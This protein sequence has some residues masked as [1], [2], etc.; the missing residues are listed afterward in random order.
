[1]GLGWLTPNEYADTF[2]PRRDLT[3]RSLTGSAPAPVA[4]PGQI[5][6]SNRPSLRQAG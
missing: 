4:Q 5:G 2:N 3:L 6:Q 1:S